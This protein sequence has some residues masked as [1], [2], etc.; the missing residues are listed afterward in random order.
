MFHQ[1]NLHLHVREY[2]KAYLFQVQQL[3]VIGSSNTR[4]DSDN[5]HLSHL[6][7]SKLLLY[8]T[9]NLEEWMENFA[10]YQF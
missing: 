1:E 4:I 2:R 6:F 10:R 7:V 9:I 3:V 5:N 8:H